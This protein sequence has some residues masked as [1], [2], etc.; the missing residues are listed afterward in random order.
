MTQWPE[1][2]KSSMQAGC[3][4]PNKYP[5]PGESSDSTHLEVDLLADST[6]DSYAAPQLQA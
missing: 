1:A 5:K 4:G 6:A 2:A 3:S